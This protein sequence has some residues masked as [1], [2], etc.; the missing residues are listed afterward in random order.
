[1]QGVA[2]NRIFELRKRLIVPNFIVI[3]H[4]ELAER[5]VAIRVRCVGTIGTGGKRPLLG[6]VMMAFKSVLTIVST[7]SIFKIG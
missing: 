7:L 5:L 2:D 4:G 6:P 1:M 3:N